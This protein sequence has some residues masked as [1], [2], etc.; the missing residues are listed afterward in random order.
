MQGL[1]ILQILSEMKNAGRLLGLTELSWQGW[2]APKHP[3]LPARQGRPAAPS[4]LG[5]SPSTLP[6]WCHIPDLLH[7]TQAVGELQTGWILQVVRCIFA[8]FVSS[9]DTQQNC[10]CF[11]AGRQS[12]TPSQ[13][14]L[15][16]AGTGLL[17]A[18]A[19]LVWQL[20]SSAAPKQLCSL[21]GTR[22]APSSSCKSC[23]ELKSIS[24]GKDW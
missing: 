1:N 12:K 10:P 7:D 5:S 2:A 16:T 8:T 21:S 9:L 4:G 13:A 22:L 23:S 3:A 20:Q 24:A 18:I 14:G 11:E 6:S 19:A 17:E 15:S